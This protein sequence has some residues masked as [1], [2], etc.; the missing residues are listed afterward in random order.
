MANTTKKKQGKKADR[1]VFFA[2]RASTPKAAGLTDG[3][4]DGDGGNDTVP[5][6]YSPGPQNLPV[7]QDFLQNCLEDM[8]T[9]IL[10]SLQS[11]LKELRRDVQELED[12]MTHVEQ[13]MEDQTAAHND[14]ADQVQHMQQQLEYTQRKVMDLEDRSR[15]QNLRLR[16]IPEEVKQPDLHAFLIGYFKELAP[17]LPAEVLLLDR[18]HRVQKPTFLPQDTPRDVLTHLHYFLVKEALLQA[19]RGGRDLPQK[20]KHIKLFTDL[21]A[22]TLQKRKEFKDVT[23]ALRQNNVQYRWGYPIR[24]LIRRNGTVTTANTP[25][26]GRRLLRT[27]NI[28]VNPVGKNMAAPA[29]LSPEWKRTKK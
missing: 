17:D 10:T 23:E 9:K 18:Y 11:T 26:E 6:Q 21:S 12:R 25:E 27:W 1:S 15:R 14:V 3:D 19:T 20:Y 22:A 5:L 2:A 16:G 24:L 29:M 4:Q 28:P 8:S 13:K 7:T